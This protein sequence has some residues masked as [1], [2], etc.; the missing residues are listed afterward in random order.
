[1]QNETASTAFLKY[2]SVFRNFSEEFKESLICQAKRIPAQQSLSQFLQFSCDTYIEVQSGIGVLLVSED[3]ESGNI[4]E[5]GM[6]H[7]IHI[8]PKVFC[9]ATIRGE[10]G[11]SAN[12]SKNQVADYIFVINYRLGN[13]YKPCMA[14]PYFR[15][16]CLTA[17]FKQTHI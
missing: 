15:F 11:F 8:K 17:F 13:A 16:Q 3:P 4:A 14:N 1:M 10:I 6:N 5:F 7:R 2:G 12:F 9:I